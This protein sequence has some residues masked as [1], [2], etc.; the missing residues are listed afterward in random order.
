MA[1]SIRKAELADLDRVVEFGAAFHTASMQP[2][3]FDEAAA[4][5]FSAGLITNPGGVVLLSEGGMIGGMLAPAY[6]APSWV[7]AVEL[8][9]WAESGGLALLS[10]FEEWAEGMG[11]SEV[12][13]TSLAALPRADKLLRR[14]GYDAAEIS[15][16]KVV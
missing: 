6:C 16:R 15:Y 2:F 5:E 8:F 9:W 3:P 12:R 1:T 13:M 4:R 10:A 14:K 7:M 11:A